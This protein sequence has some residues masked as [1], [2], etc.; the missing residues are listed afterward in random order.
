MSEIKIAS[1]DIDGTLL[2][3]NREITP[4][5]K[6]AIADA[7]AKG[8][9]VVI[10]TGRPLS[11]VK[12]ILDELGMDGDD[13]YVITHNGGLIESASGKRTLFR[14]ELS[15]AQFKMIQDFMDAHDTYVQVESADRAYTIDHKIGYWASYENVLVDLPLQVF[16]NLDEMAHVEFIKAIAMAN[17]DDLDKVQADVP[18]SIKDDVAVVRSTAQNLEFMNKTAS[19]GNAL[20]A[21]AKEL[22]VNPKD[23]LA[24]GDQ[25]NDHSMI[26]AAGIGVAMGNAVP[27]IKAAADV[28]TT[29]NNHDGV[30][31]ALK[32]YVL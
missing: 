18:A 16:E 32:K 4:A 19:K 7:E 15:L 26:E 23:T 12:K 11:G 24:I 3:D 28:E 30:A 31:E 13:Q 1:I 8:V 25:E 2:N 10:T 17:K 9:K 21:L 22:G 5:V 14:A 20:M 27:G 29:D 6:Q